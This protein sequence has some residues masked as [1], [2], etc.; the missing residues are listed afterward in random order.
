ME[1]KLFKALWGMTGTLEEQIERIAEAGY[2]GVECLVPDKEDVPRFRRLLER[3][4][5]DYIAMM[6][7]D[8]DHAATFRDRLNRACELEPLK[9]NSHSAK[10]W[11]PFDEQRAFFEQAMKAERDV[12]IP[13]A[14]E[15]H[16]NR[17]TYSAWSTAALLKEFPEMKLTADFSH[18][19]VVSETLLEDQRDNVELAISRTIH[20]HGRVGF[21]H[22][23]QVPDPAAPE[24]AQER[25]AHEAWWDEICRSHYARGERIVTFDPEFGPPKYLH[26]LPYT[27]QPLADL[28][29]VCKWMGD[30]YR[31][32]FRR[33]RWE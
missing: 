3:Y 2:D 16:R 25:E 1:L 17:A 6:Y 14:H 18:W 23:P 15:T 8:G 10:D 7:T 22:G 19:V 20:I 11:M 33:I 29:Q 4:G 13:V 12:P 30:A 31:D 24:Y 21:R 28:W 9:V 27:G 26:T 32:R 5:L